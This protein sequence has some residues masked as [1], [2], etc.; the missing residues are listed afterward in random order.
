MKTAS[1]NFIMKLVL[2]LWTLKGSEAPQWSQI[3]LLRTTEVVIL[4]LTIIWLCW[5]IGHVSG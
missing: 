4:W 3:T 5:V 1:N 2:I